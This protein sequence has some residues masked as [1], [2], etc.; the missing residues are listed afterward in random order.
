MVDTRCWMPEVEGDDN[1]FIVEI[2]SRRKVQ[3]SS[4]PQSPIPQ[5][6]ILVLYRKP[7]LLQNL[8]S[9]ED[10]DIGFDHFLYEIGEIV[11]GFPA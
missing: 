8:F 10:I 11:F 5:S 7:T 9:S 2:S 4:I 1:T 6:F 3:R